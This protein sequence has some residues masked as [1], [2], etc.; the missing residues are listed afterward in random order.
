MRS[1]RMQPRS[2]HETPLDFDGFLGV[3]RG[4]DNIS[5]PARWIVWSPFIGFVVAHCFGFD[6]D[7][8]GGM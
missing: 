5:S 6:D 8:Y 2:F 4:E 1:I 7:D 3:E